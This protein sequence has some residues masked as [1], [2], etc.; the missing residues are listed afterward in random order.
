MSHETTHQQRTTEW[1]REGRE[2]KWRAHKRNADR[3]K[4]LII[5]I[6]ENVMLRTDHSNKLDKIPIFNRFKCRKA[7]C[8]IWMHYFFF[9]NKSMYF[10]MF[11][12]VVFISSYSS[13]HPPIFQWSF[14]KNLNLLYVHWKRWMRKIF[15]LL[16]K[17]ET[18][19]E[20]LKYGKK[21]KLSNVIVQ[22]RCSIGLIMTT[23]HFLCPGRRKICYKW[24]GKKVILSKKYNNPL[25]FI[26][27]YEP[28]QQID[29]L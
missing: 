27:L 17:I 19:S 11:I 18:K 13:N 9:E 26:S 3:L 24:R 20:T 10:V 2:K 1:M 14:D 12:S 4:K 8:I 25:F 5:H 29:I 21:I 28:F 16:N 22:H 15:C 23:A 6:L 7:N